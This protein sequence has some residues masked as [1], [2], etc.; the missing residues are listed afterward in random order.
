METPIGGL[1]PS[2]M[3]GMRTP[4]GGLGPPWRGWGGIDRGVGGWD[5]MEGERGGKETPIERLGGWDPH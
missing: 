1:G 2:L 5:P 4:I 3:G